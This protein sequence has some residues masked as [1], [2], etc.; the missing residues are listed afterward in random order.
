[1]NFPAMNRARRAGPLAL[2]LAASVVAATLAGCASE[3]GLQGRLN[4]EAQ[5][6]TASLGVT[7]LSLKEPVAQAQVPAS[8][9]WWK[10][11]GDASLDQL[12]DQ[13]L[14][15][16]PTLKVVQAR[17][18]KALSGEMYAGAAH[19]PAVQARAEADRVRYTGVG[20][21]PPPLAGSVRTLG[22]LQLE[23]EVNLDLFGRHR[24]E[25]EAAIGQRQAAL[26]DQAAAR[27]QLSAQ[28]ARQY[29][30]L[31]RLVAQREVASRNLDQRQE[32]LALIRQRVQA[33]LDTQVE[34][35]QGEGALPDT[36]QQLEAL[37]EQIRL[38]R[39]QLAAL[40][41]QPP[42]ATA[43]L[44]PAWPRLQLAALPE[45]VP[46]NL[47]GQRADV[48]ALKWRAQ[49]ATAQS[50]AARTLFY[51]DLNLKGY[52]GLSAIGLD[53]VFKSDAQQWGV[54]PALDLPLFDGDRRR[55][56]LQSHLA[57]QDAAIAAY[58]QGVIDAVREVSEQLVSA[59][60]VARQLAEQQQAQQAAEAAYQV[61]VQRY[62]AGLGPYL[63]VLQA[64]GQVLQ[65]RRLGVDLQAR[66]FD[67]R[68][69]LARALGGHWPA[70]Q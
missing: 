43:T 14:A 62:K 52:L 6:A 32:L 58:E 55:A 29:L 20:P 61:A 44:A 51:P 49:A 57:D 66:A 7:P 22:T 26:A 37:D 56:N 3:A 11:L 34:L 9:A 42:A 21:Y 10:A 31:G 1:M 35:K 47:L 27:T 33:G 40:T 19:L 67:T 23:G 38:S 5:P 46:L 53:R 64:E 65:Q 60:S 25:L 18:D 15:S 24:A 70:A 45:R 69:G 12:I 17:V 50:D 28:V 30:Q 39:L 2:A 59:D 8:E 54:M 41:A 48:L 36:R 13:A 16:S 4:A 68:V 63:T